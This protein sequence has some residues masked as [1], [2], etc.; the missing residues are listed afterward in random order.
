MGKNSLTTDTCAGIF[1]K[2]WTRRFKEEAGEKDVPT[3]QEKEKVESWLQKKNEHEERSPC[4]QQ[5]KVKGK[6]ETKS[7]ILRRK[8][9]KR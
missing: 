7:L 4:D 3:E 2:L 5:K 6:K 9:S 8:E 1:L